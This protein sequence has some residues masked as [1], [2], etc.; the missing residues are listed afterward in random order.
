MHYQLRQYLVKQLFYAY[1]IQFWHGWPLVKVTD[2]LQSMY[3]VTEI[4]YFLL[5]WFLFP[6]LNA[7]SLWNDTVQI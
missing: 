7:I 3:E 1:Y 5:Y 6:V 4:E 2:L